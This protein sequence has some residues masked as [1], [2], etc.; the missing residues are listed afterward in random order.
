MK[1]YEDFVG[2]TD[3]KGAQARVVKYEKKFI[4]TQ[5]L[6][7]ES[8]SKITDIQKKIKV[9]N[10]DCFFYCNFLFSNIGYSSGTGKDP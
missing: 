3:V 1:R 7:R 5:E 2:L 4:E 6:R 8:Q 10:N 9:I